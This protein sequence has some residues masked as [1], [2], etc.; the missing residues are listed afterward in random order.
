MVKK[1]LLALGIIAVMVLGQ[2]S[3]VFAAGTY[4]ISQLTRSGGLIT[5]S[6]TYTPTNSNSKNLGDRVEV[7]C[8][9]S[10]Q[11]KMYNRT[12]YGV[13][14]V[15]TTLMGFSGSPTVGFNVGLVKNENTYAYE[16]FGY[17]T[18]KWRT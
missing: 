11:E 16:E 12:T 7:Y 3:S 4:N 1:K 14:A 13:N 5:G 15:S 10:G 9:V 2:N 18:T 8:D 17:T 6:V